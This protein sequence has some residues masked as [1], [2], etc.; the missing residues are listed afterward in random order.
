MPGLPSCVCAQLIKYGVVRMA[1]LQRDLLHW[2][3]LYCAGRLHKPVAT[4]RQHAAVTAAQQHNLQAALRVALLLLPQKFSTLVSA[5]R[6]GCGC[7]RRTC[8]SCCPP[9]PMHVIVRAYWVMH[10]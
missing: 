3:S 1:A 7:R 4:L 10:A 2:N 9:C 5:R 8:V 6:A